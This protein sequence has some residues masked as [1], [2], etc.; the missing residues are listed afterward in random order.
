MRNSIFSLILFFISCPANSIVKIEHW[1]TTQG[2]PVFYVAN[3]NLPLVD[4]RIVLDAGSARD[5]QQYGLA[6]LTSA[7]LSNGAGT[8]NADEIARRFAD[9]GARFETDVS[10]DMSLLSLR[11]LSEEKPFNQAL[12]TL[13]V[14]LTQPTF[15]LA[16][17]KREKNITLAGLKRTEESPHAIAKIE[18][19]KILYQNHPYAHP[20][21]GTTKKV[22]KLSTSDLNNFY[23]KYYISNNAMVVIVGDLNKQQAIKTAEFLTAN[24]KIN[25]KPAALIDAGLNKL[26]VKKHIEFASSQTHILAGMLGMHRKDPDY[27][28]LY[29]GNYILGGSGLVSRLFKEVRDKRGLAYSAYSYFLSMSK[30]GVFALNLQ[31]RSDQTKKATQILQKTLVDF[32]KIGPT[33]EE[34]LAAKKNIIGGFALRFDTNSKLT[35]YVALIGFYKFPLDYLHKFRQQVEAVTV[36]SIKDAFKRRVIPEFI[37]TVTVGRLTTK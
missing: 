16:D 12:Q 29:V 26:G 34:L 6:S 13:Q 3:K 24:L 27:F 11:T 8:W 31:T 7:M 21:A 5:G 15:N 28:S 4:I 18:F 1:K 23:T 17:F 36:T 19:F 14:I 10:R 9:V 25:T 30:K 22:L 35:D 32:I 20:V 2:S 33:E 37:N